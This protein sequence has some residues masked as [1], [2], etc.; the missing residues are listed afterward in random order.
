MTGVYTAYWHARICLKMPFRVD[1]LAKSHSYGRLRKK[2][3][4]KEC[5]S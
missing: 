5:K 1:G 3:A 4:G 2:A